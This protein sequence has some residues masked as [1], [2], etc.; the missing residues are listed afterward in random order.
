ME[1]V[2]VSSMRKS[3]L[4]AYLGLVIGLTPAHANFV[5]K[6]HTARNL[7][8]TDPDA[9]LQMMRKSF[10]SAVELNHADY[11]TAAGNTICFWLHEMGRTV[12]AGRFARSVLDAIQPMNYRENDN[13]A[14]RR[15]VTFGFLENGLL[16]EGRI[17]T[18]MQANRAAGE[19]LRGNQV[20]AGADGRS[21]TIAEIAGLPADRRAVG[22]RLIDRQARLLDLMGR[23][24][25]AR[26]L[27][28][29]AAT[30]LG[31]R[32]TTFDTHERFYA[33]QLL[34]NRTE[35]LQFLGYEEAALDAQRAL[36]KASE[37]LPLRSGRD[38]LRM[39]H[40]RDLS[41]WAGP[42]EEIL[43]EARE[44]AEILGK[45]VPG[46]PARR[47]L[48]K[49]ELDFQQ[50]RQ[51][52]DILRDEARKE[53]GLGHWF[54]TAY[55]DRDLLVAR[56]AT[57]EAGLDGEFISILTRMR[58]QGNKRGEPVLYQ[59]YGSYLLA[60]GRPAEAIAMFEESLRMKRAFGLLLHEP[61]L[62][63]RILTARFEAGDID[64]ARAS[65]AELDAFLN[66]HHHTMPSG[67]RAQ[68][69]ILRA[70]ALAR[71]GEIH[72]ARESLELARRLSADL[73]PYRRML[74]E[75]DQEHRI[76]APPPTTPA[77]ATEPAEAPRIRIQPLHVV[78]IADPGAPANTRF[79]VSNPSSRSMTGKWLIT[80]PAAR[81]SHT[82]HV[83]FHEGKPR[84]TLEIPHT[85]PAGGQLVIHTS[86]THSSDAGENIAAGIEV[87]WQS[88]GG[89]TTPPSMW[90]ITWQ[91]EAADR[92]VLDTSELETSPF[93]A[94]SLFHELFLPI[95]EVAGLPIR[96]HSPVPLRLEYYDATTGE[97]LAIDANGNG[98]FTEPGDAYTPNPF[99]VQAAMLRARPDRDTLTLEVRIAAP[100]GNPILID[101][102]IILISEA[103]RDGEWVAQAENILR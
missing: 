80:G 86:I 17:G 8:A 53:A 95:G 65:L 71:F 68:V 35:L 45:K 31:D 59:Q 33:F 85:I 91:R 5:E 102:E 23:S 1:R 7:H 89:E 19:N 18:A 87:R 46:T 34:S 12:E 100:C 78:T 94:I 30:A 88:S 101:P 51:A 3:F 39:N 103:F 61:L 48:A 40:L 26:I 72:A 11:A 76:L 49:M 47:L 62:I 25:D 28:D 37:G 69:E 64:G 58:E 96:M 22:W 24:F 32:W 90:E 54:E 70:T 81:F 92:I 44:I 73:P 50:S 16:A 52:I 99:G 9:A 93:R 15:A 97:L 36:L 82:G 75:P 38:I 56:A 41:Q 98:N 77:S 6:Y 57:G 14:L 63:S 21:I 10:T 60:Q 29:E 67:R 27:M 2:H 13:D 42:T 84:A 43:A 20:P 79:S 66:K 83:T 74:L 55:T 4:R